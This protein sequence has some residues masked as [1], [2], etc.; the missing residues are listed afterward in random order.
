MRMGWGGWSEKA[1]PGAVMRQTKRSST[2]YARQCPRGPAKHS[3]VRGGY[4][5]GRS[6]TVG[7]FRACLGL[8]E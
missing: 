3:L 8:S 4:G 1:M 5:T 6:S 2:V 7:Q